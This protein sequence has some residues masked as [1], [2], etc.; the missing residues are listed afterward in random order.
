M[1]VHSVRTYTGAVTGIAIG[2]GVA[3]FILIAI[4]NT[5]YHRCCRATSPSDLHP[6]SFGSLAD[7]MI[8]CGVGVGG[9]AAIT[10]IVGLTMGLNSNLCCA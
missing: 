4:C 1:Y 2:S 3:F 9:A 5:L 7:F 6:H 8:G 10:L